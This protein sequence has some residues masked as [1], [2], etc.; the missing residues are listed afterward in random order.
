MLVLINCFSG[1]QQAGLIPALETNEGLF[2]IWLIKYLSDA[3][4]PPVILLS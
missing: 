3:I 2:I 1:V 4:T